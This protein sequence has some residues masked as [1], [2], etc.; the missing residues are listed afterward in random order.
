M[1]GVIMIDWCLQCGCDEP[2]H[3]QA[4]THKFMS[5]V[6][7]VQLLNLLETEKTQFHFQPR[8]TERKDTPAMTTPAFTM[9]H[10][11]ITIVLDGKTYTV[12]ANTPQYFGLRDCIFRED[13]AAIGKHVSL[14]GALQQWL[15]D[16]FV[17]DGKTI[18][19]E[20]QAMPDSLVKRIWEMAGKGESPGPLFAFYERLSRNPSQRSVLQLFD[21]LA[22]G[23]IP[24]EPDG[25]F[26]AYKSVRSDYKDAHSGTFDNS[27]G[28]THRMPRNQISDD[29]RHACHEGF[30]VGALGYAHDFSQRLVI[31][32]V[33]PEHVVCVPYDYNSQKMRVCEYVVI[34]NHVGE[35]PT[36]TM[37]STTFAHD[38]EEQADPDW[39]GDVEGEDDDLI[40]GEPVV[41]KKP[42]VI[43]SKPTGPKAAAFARM[44][45]SKLMEQSID[46]LRKYAAAHLKI[47]GASK[48][49]G[50]K[51]SLVSKILK[52]RKQRRR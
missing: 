13:W 37:P 14:T 25:T 48:L 22:H 10:E 28:N 51:S 46:D 32:R 39:A 19:Y 17:V 44:N 36:A 52:V 12:Q 50:G 8:T 2:D 6:A 41:E 29:P 15:G 45:P 5:A 9:T 34:G 38:V 7:T 23:G 11:S 43:T 24:I 21:F 20:G 1:S 27:P 49:P 33:D 3:A 30:H 35:G 4:V 26:L 16:K 18:S 31:V 47:V 40:E 42:I